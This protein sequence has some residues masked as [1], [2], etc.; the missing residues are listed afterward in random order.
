MPIHNAF[1]GRHVRL[2]AAAALALCAGAVSAQS[3]VGLTSANELTRFSAA[4]PAMATTVDITGLVAG[5]RF[6]GIDLRPSNNTIYGITQSNRLY[7]LNEFTGAATFVAALSMPVVSTALGYGFD[8]NPVADYGGA[9]SLRLV[10]SDGGNFAINANTGAVTVATSIASGYSAVAYSNSAP[11][12]SAPASTT[13][14]YINSG[15][16]ALASTPTGFN[17]PVISTLG[18]LGVDALRANGFEITGGM[19]IA[20]LNL[21]AGTSLTTGI[22]GIN[23]GS[24]AATLMGTY[25]G[26]LSGLTVSAV[27]EPGTYGLLAAGLAVVGLLARRRRAA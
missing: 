13:L 7:T 5:D 15:T 25:N 4:N 19:G 1:R 20:A 10:G 24:G 21:D 26:T 8:F 18:A 27:P 16:D 23:L 6:I 22:Y 12:S 9:T 11:F 3:L 14:Y 2:A 17:N